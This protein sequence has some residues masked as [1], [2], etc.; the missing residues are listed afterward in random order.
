MKLYST[1]KKV[2]RVSLN[3]SYKQSLRRK[4]LISVTKEPDEKYSYWNA[5]VS[6]PVKIFQRNVNSITVNI[7][8]RL[9]MS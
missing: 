3:K 1:G 9:Q 2:V 8:R 4:E 5:G 7:Y 6:F